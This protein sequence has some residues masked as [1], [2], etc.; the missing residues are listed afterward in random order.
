MDIAIRVV[1]AK[2]KEAIESIIQKSE[3][4]TDE[5]KFCAVELLD[6][7]IKDMAKGE[8]LFICA[9]DETDKP[10]GY[11]C[12]GKTPFADGVY[13]IYWIAIDPLWQGKSIGRILIKHLEG[14]LRKEGARMV[15]AETSSQ[16]KYKKA[17][18]LYERAGFNDVSRIKDFYR[19]GDD[20]IVYVKQV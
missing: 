15:V 6:I 10:I 9:A 7:Y 13:D 14:I 5:E 3:N 18:L 8:Y 20:K 19:A 17:R 2:D 1:A 4:F 11:I 16:P 12:Y